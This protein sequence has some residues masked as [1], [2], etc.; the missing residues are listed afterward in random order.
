MA[1]ERNEGFLC[2]KNSLSLSSLFPSTFV[3][4]S[5]FF[6]CLDLSISSRVTYILIHLKTCQSASV[7]YSPSFPF[8]FFVSLHLPLSLSLSIPPPFSL[9]SL[10]LSLLFLS[11]IFPSSL[12]SP[13]LFHTFPSLLTCLPS[14]PLSIPLPLALMPSCLRA[15]VI[16]RRDETPA[17]H[18][19]SHILL[20][21][22][23]R[24]FITAA[25]F[26]VITST[27]ISP[28]TIT[29]APP[30]TPRAALPVL[31]PAIRPECL[32]RIQTL[33]TRGRKPIR[34]HPRPFLPIPRLLSLLPFFSPLLSS[35]SILKR[36]INNSIRK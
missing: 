1:L 22:A 11:R 30:I 33:V 29:D 23:L 2:L 32:E 24:E 3:W 25:V 35:L 6:V 19:H 17:G 8:S 36:F 34:S 5:A 10:S 7:S 28:Q 16:E 9:I 4:L 31:T 15:R 14:L 13:F 18:N 20:P 26:G 12:L 27:Q 21:D